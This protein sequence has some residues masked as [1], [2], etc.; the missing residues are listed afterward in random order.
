[1]SL[2]RRDSY[3]DHWRGLFH[4]VILADHLPFLLPGLFT[5]ISGFYEALGYISVAEG[6]VFLSGYVT[7]LVY[8][9]E[10]EK[11]GAR[12]MWLK[13]GKRAFMIYATY[14][15]AVVLLLFLVRREG[16]SDIFWGSWRHL[17]EE[18][19]P[20]AFTQVAL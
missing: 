20:T 1:M 3:L 2:I 18:S 7:G 10:N 12:S 17:L 15:G 19:G 13:A 6:F 5:L 11:N 8:T 4:V 16:S 9:R 14:V